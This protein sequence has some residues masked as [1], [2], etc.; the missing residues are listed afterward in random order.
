MAD[1]FRAYLD[2]VRLLSACGSNAADLHGV[3][4]TPSLV[5]EAEWAQTTLIGGERWRPCIQRL[6]H[7]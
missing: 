4:P 7:L 1:R 2:A 5:D 6:G 3:S